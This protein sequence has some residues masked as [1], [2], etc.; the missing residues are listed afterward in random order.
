MKKST[1]VLLVLIALSI[2][3]AAVLILTMPGEISTHFKTMHEGFLQEGFAQHHLEAGE[4]FAHRPGAA[5]GRHGGGGIL[6]GIGA[7]V[8]GI[9]SAHHRKNHGKK[10][11]GE[12]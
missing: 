2:A 10:N 9:M 7:F 4:G 3:L 5:H 11:G 1:V 12:V 8:L 6:L